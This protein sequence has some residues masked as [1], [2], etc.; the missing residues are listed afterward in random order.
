MNNLSY[1][2]CL[3]YSYDIVTIVLLIGS[4][5]LKATVFFFLVEI[6]SPYLEVIVS[7]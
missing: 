7:S 1:R 6:F 2:K 3:F 5:P 4:L